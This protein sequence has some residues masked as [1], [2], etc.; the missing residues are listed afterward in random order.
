MYT[1]MECDVDVEQL[2]RERNQLRILFL[3]GQTPEGRA[4]ADRLDGMEYKKQD[5]VLIREV[6]ACQQRVNFSKFQFGQQMAR[7]KEVSKVRKNN[8]MKRGHW[9]KVNAAQAI[10]LR[11]RGFETRCIGLKDW[12]VFE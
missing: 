10:L 8:S 9:R 1:Q 4:S 2:E 11:Q 5:D 12:E 3:A 6:A 7:A